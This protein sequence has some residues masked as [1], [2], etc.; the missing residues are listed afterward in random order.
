[1]SSSRPTSPTSSMQ[2]PSD[3]PPPLSPPSRAPDLTLRMTALA[4]QIA[5]GIRGPASQYYCKLLEDRITSVRTLP[6]PPLLGVVT[7][8]VKGNEELIQPG[9]CGPPRPRVS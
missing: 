3:P 8:T 7:H 2:S 6:E 1:M 5:F 9:A 4:C